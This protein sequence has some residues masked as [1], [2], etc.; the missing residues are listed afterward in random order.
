MLKPNSR[1]LRLLVIASVF[2]LCVGAWP[3]S[4]LGQ[5]VTGT[6]QGTVADAKG[7]VV[8][9]ADI[10]LKNTETGL[11]RN[12]KTNSQGF[13]IASFLPIGRYT[14]TAAM[15]GFKTTTTEVEVAL[16]QT[17]VID[18]ALEP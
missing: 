16:N 7:A 10:V 1:D 9:G 11:E 6:L 3:N 17:R 14:I 2:L 4:V 8:P 13:F 18:I 12:L 5:T 15:K